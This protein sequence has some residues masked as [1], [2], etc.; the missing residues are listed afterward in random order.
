MKKTMQR[1]KNERG[2]T[3]V[4]LLAVIVI[5]AIIA[6]IAFV[7]IGGIIENSKKDAHIANAE[8]I[9]S[10]AKLYEST[11][12]NLPVKVEQLQDSEHLETLFD[13]WTKNTYGEDAEVDKDGSDYKLSAD[14]EGDG[15]TIKAGTTEQSIL[16]GDRDNLC[17]E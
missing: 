2:L 9:I 15:C 5:L 1:L 11:G 6:V 7:F 4:E 12:G 8:Q 16:Q 3:L 17:D 14:F 10:A 13:P